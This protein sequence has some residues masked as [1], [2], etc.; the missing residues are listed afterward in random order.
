MKVPIPAICILLALQGALGD[1]TKT[2]GVARFA[3]C[4]TAALETAS[5]ESVADV[6]AWVRG[7]LRGD[8]D[9]VV[10]PEMAFTTFSEF[11]DAWR[12]APAVWR[13][14]ADFAVERDAWVFVN[15]PNREGSGADA[16][17][18]NETR[19]FS[20][21]GG[22]AAVY[23]KRVLANMDG[24]AGFSPGAE[25]T[26]AD[27]PFARIGLL[28]CKDAYYP[29]KGG[30]GYVAADMLLVQFSHP[31][32]DDRDAPEAAGF[33][34][35]AQSLKDLRRSRYGWSHLKVPFAAANKDGP[36]GNYVLCG[37][38]F[39]A[40]SDGTAFAGRK[41]GAGVV[42]A[43]FPLRDDGRIAAPP[44]FE[45]SLD[46]AGGSVSASRLLVGR[47]S[48]I[49]PLPVPARKGHVFLGWYTS[50]D[51]GSRVSASTRP[52]R[53]LPIFARWKPTTYRIAFSA[54]GGT[55]PKGRTMAAQKM[56]YGKAAALRG[57][58]FARSGHV[59]LGWAKSKTGAVAYKNGQSVKNLRADGG[60][61]TLYAV[62]AKSRYR[63]SFQANGGSGSMA[64]QTFAYGKA[65]SL[66]AN[67]FKA[68]RGKRFAGWAK[69]AAD[70]RRGKVAYRDGQAVKN[71]LANGKTAKLYA[72]WK[73]K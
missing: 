45:V 69:S 44:P 62:W 22:L 32:V 73:K 10:L 19:V 54:N 48:A 40:D 34:S 58:A 27:L 41:S 59:F 47:G 7:R 8:E 68:P 64:V 56:A 18:F 31:G 14:A 21:D 16:R 26:V 53:D 43:D 67:R 12:Y 63:V 55:L 36:D 1:T 72:V 25:A 46:P 15:H 35:S 52:S 24:A 2:P 66:S 6:F 33:P 13:Q 49:G 38:T 51:G 11:P 65:Q 37:G 71:L 17:L 3:L 5:E 61:T 4:Q 57:N 39:A 60:T 50:R 9:A 28:I 70:A 30:D 42:F 29:E 23:R 20:P